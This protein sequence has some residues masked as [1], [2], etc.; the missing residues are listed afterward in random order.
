MEAEMHVILRKR[1]RHLQNFRYD[2][3]LDPDLLNNLDRKNITTAQFIFSDCCSVEE[4]SEKLG[5]LPSLTSLEVSVDVEQLYQYEDVDGDNPLE[6]AKA[7][8]DLLRCL[9]LRI[10]GLGYAKDTE[11]S[12]PAQTL[13]LKSLHLW[14][15]HLR[16]AMAVM[17]TAMVPDLLTTLTLQNCHAFQIS[18]I[19]ATWLKSLQSLT[20]ANPETVTVGLDFHNINRMLRQIRSLRRLIVSGMQLI[21]GGYLSNDAVMKHSESLQCLYVCIVDQQQKPCAT[22][23]ALMKAIS[24]CSNL[25][26]VGLTLGIMSNEDSTWSSHLVA[27][28]VVSHRQRKRMTAH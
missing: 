25:R 20:I 16:K 1:Q 15:F 22:P 9:L 8:H 27:R 12:V 28:S 4:Y 14:G 2:Q 23:E 13:A 10:Q 11:Q 7:C 6:C 5:H 24:R 3:S 19:D 18:G 21:P 26:Q 17:A